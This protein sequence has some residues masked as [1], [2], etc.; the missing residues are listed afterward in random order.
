MVSS[1]KAVMTWAILAAATGFTGPFGS[2]AHMPLATRLVYWPLVVAAVILLGSGVRVFVHCK[3]GLRSFWRGAVAVMVLNV[4]V[5]V[6][7]LVLLS[8]LA[9]GAI[10]PSAIEFAGFVIAGS[11]G[12]SALRWTL[13]IDARKAVPTAGLSS[14]PAAAPMPVAGPGSDPDAVPT[15]EDRPQPPRLITRLPERERGALLRISGRNHHV[16]IHTER[17]TSR[18]L[19]RFSD[20]VAETAPVEGLQVHRSH[21]VALSSVKGVATRSG[22]TVLVM[23]DGAEVPVSRNY[24]EAVASAGIG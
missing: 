14:V 6:P 1:R 12:I 15:P 22:K 4:L 5:F 17:G 11:L 9:T 3:L 24:R 7:L 21:W 13:G 10:V 16:E 19:L 18:I 23:L 20:A 8:P 2:Y